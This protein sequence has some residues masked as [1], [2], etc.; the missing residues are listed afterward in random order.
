M[1]KSRRHYWYLA[2]R[3]ADMPIPYVPAEMGTCGLCGSSVWMAKMQRSY[4]TK[5]EGII[6]MMCL[7]D[8]VEGR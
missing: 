2:N 5:A 3:V 7:A 1:R 8:R 6:C 4:W